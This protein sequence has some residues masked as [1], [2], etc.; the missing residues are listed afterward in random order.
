MGHILLKLVAFALAAGFVWMVVR[1]FRLGR[2]PGVRDWFVVRYARRD[3]TPLLF[4]IFTIGRAAV[5]GIVVL[6]LFS[7][8]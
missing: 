3:E 5:I 6:T 4:W 8:E 2:A 7:L 1:D